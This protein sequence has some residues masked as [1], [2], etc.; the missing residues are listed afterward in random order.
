[1][2]LDATTAVRK[3]IEDKRIS[4][5]GSEGIIFDADLNLQAVGWNLVGQIWY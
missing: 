3:R 4:E 1:M 5:L 2:I